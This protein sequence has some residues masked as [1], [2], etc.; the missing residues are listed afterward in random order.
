M[1]TSLRGQRSNRTRV[2]GETLKSK[3]FF[4]R[5]PSTNSRSSEH[6][7]FYKF[8]AGCRQRHVESCGPHK[9]IAA[10]TIVAVVGTTRVYVQPD[11]IVCR[12]V[13]RTFYRRRNTHVFCTSTTR[14]VR[15]VSGGKRRN[16]SFYSLSTVFE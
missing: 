13:F 5:T 2:F 8:P 10:I 12:R 6:A 1:R 7:G 11:R 14:N 15:P 9:R 4:F 3:L 16:T